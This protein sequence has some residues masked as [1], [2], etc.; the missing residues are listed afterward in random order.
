MDNTE[1]SFYWWT[2]C[3]IVELMKLNTYERVLAD[4]EEV[5]L[6]EQSDNGKL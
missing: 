5:L 2:I 3:A 4:I 1:E 6:R